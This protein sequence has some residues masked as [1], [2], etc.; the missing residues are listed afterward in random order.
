MRRISLALATLAAF[1]CLVASAQAVSFDD[2]VRYVKRG[3]HQNKQWPWPYICADR[4]AVH[5]PFCIMVN[6]GWRRQN[7]LGAHHFNEDATKLTTAGELRVR[8]ILTQAPPE[9]R[10][11]FVER[12]LNPTVTAE[13]LAAA[14]DYASQVIID[15]GAPVVVESNL[16]SEGRPA[17]LVD[18]TNVRFQESMPVPALPATSV[19]IST[20]TGQ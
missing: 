20:G 9:R 5:E 18:A 14:R 16:I 19:G 8:W 6:N 2:G 12:D 15:G 4:I 17:S 1:G 13:R 11:I 3:Y 7:L 10:T